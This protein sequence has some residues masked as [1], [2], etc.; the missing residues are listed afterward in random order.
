MD[1]TFDIYEYLI[2][3][4]CIQIIG[5]LFRVYYN[6]LWLCCFLYILIYIPIGLG[7]I[8]TQNISSS[9]GLGIQNLSFL[10]DW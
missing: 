2:L 7:Y 9:W 8:N 5:F 10:V 1:L 6:I 3:L 4:N